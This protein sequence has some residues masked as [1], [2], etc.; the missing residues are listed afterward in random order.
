MRQQFSG[1]KTQHHT[2]P[3]QKRPISFVTGLALV[4]S[5]LVTTG[6]A[7]AQDEAEGVLGIEEIIVTA[8]K[9]EQGVNDIGIT[10]NAF[11]GAQLKDLGVFTAEQI[12]Q[13]TPG[14]TVNDTAATGVPLYTIRGV[15][16]QDYSTGASSTV[17][18]YFDEV[19]IP[20]TVMSRG[21]MFDVQR[22]EVL[23]G[24]QGDLY[25]RNTTAGQINF[26]SNKPSDEFE[27]GFNVSYGR[28]NVFDLEGF[29]TGGLGDSVQGR[30]SF[31]TTQSNK[32]WQKSLTRD[33]ELGELDS[34]A[35]RALFNFDINDDARILLNFH[36]VND[37]SDNKANTVYD[38]TDAGLGPFALPYTPLDQYLLPTGAHFGETPPWYSTGDNRSADWTNSYTSPLTGTTFNLRPQRDNQLKGLSIKLEWDLGGFDLTSITGYDDFQREES[39]DWDGGFFNDS[40]NINTTDIEAFSQELRFSGQTD[41]MLW[42]AGLYYS[43]DEM[44]EYYHYFMSDSLFGLGSLAWGGI[45]PFALSPILE[46]DTKYEQETTSKAIFGHVE[47]DFAEHWRLTLGARY[48][49]EE[50]DWSGC[51]FVADD[52]SLGGF[53]NT[54]FGSTLVP[55]DCGT[56]DDDPASPYFIFGLLGTPNVNDAFHVYEDTIKTDRLMGKIGLDYKLSE[57]T[58]LY[59]TIS[60]GFKSGGFNGANSNTTQQLK[61]Y[62]EEKLTSYEIGFKSTLLD[63][64]MQLNGAAF[65]YDYKDK[66][67]QDAA[68]TFV[69]NI[70]GLTNVP[71]SEIKGAELDLSWVPAAG[72]HVNFGLAYLDTEVIE[73]EAVDRDASEWPVTVT[74]DVSGIELAMAPRWSAAGL[75]SYEWPVGSNLVM[76][77]AGDFSYQ[78]DT[79]GGAQPGDATE[80][81]AILNARIGIGSD[82]GKWRV[83]LWSSNLTDEYYYPAA[84]QGGNGP[85]V[86]SV[87]MPLT[88]GVTLFYNF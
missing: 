33:D 21:V 69:G 76:E 32:G 30:V 63:G 73:W 14:L 18:L 55:G 81:Y 35:V 31:R 62:K 51:T 75:V 43:H 65:Y 86:R 16:F 74:H 1:Q 27:A 39:N 5:G 87:G 13:F 2:Y 57:D 6:Q 25:G 12:A 66:Q 9:R 49:E 41:N 34:T 47:W 10:V 28:F 46:L 53:L 64:R 61:P 7:M 88:Y 70:S 77:V 45:M 58:L 68:V 19:A 79:T 20:Y 15:G 4:I 67:E 23:K 82:D 8:Q 3:L 72:W 71:K 22:V 52:G 56:I 59:G 54:L 42:I 26:V 48:T 83:L 38:G 50:R 78:D 84:Y 85:W 17:G 37:Q 60:S 11:T 44:D 29:V 80:S 24:P 36:Y 40:S